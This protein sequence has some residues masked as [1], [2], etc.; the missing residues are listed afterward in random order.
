MSNADT[1]IAIKHARSILQKITKRMTDRSTS[2]D[3]HERLSM[4]VNKDGNGPAAGADIDHI[5]CWCGLGGCVEWL[6]EPETVE[7]P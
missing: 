5:E 6:D 3:E 1:D 2:C 4:P 7:R